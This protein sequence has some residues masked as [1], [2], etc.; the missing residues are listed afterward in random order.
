M[1]PFNARRFRGMKRLAEALVNLPRSPRWGHR[2]R[3]QLPWDGGSAPVHST[4]EN[5]PA[6]EPPVLLCDQD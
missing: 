2:R 5:T 4:Q 6:W 3:Q 1:T